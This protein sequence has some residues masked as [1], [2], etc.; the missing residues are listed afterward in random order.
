MISKNEI[1]SKLNPF[2]N[3]RTVVIQE[4]GVTDI[5]NGILDTHERYKKEYDKISDYFY[6]GSCYATA[7]NIWNFLKNN[8]RYY[9]ES[10]NQQTLRSPSAILSLPGDCKSYALFANGIMDSLRRKGLLNC[11]V[12][13][14]F[15]GYKNNRDFEHVFSVA[16]E[17]NKETWI[18][19]VLSTFDKKKLPT[20]YKDKKIN[21][22]LIAM[23]GI[24]SSLPLGPSNSAP[25]KIV[26]SGGNLLNTIKDLSGSVASTGIPLASTIASAV[27]LLTTLFANK[28]N[29]NDWMGWPAQ[30]KKQGMPVGTSANFFTKYDGDSVQNEAANIVQWIQAYGIDT[31]LGYNSWNKWT[32]TV[33]DLADKLTRGGFY[34]EAEQF[35]K[36]Y[37]GAGTSQAP[38]VMNEGGNANTTT[39]AGMNIY[40]TLALV[41]AAIFA[42]TKMKK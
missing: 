41:G 34:K 6:A 21:M 17:G 18:D 36:A 16:R 14:R 28:P 22:A 10:D 20:N 2:L 12:S 38:N 4:Q 39:K 24:P 1:L 7:Q 37:K 26:K 11:E 27:S 8:V 25:Q 19:P 33:E 31:V 42:I 13:F 3:S 40:V 29:P 9:I 15:A 35:L 5:I 30:E 23:S 32:V